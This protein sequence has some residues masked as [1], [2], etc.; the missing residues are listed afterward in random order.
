MA[1]TAEAPAGVVEVTTPDQEPEKQDN[2]LTPEQQAQRVQMLAEYNGLKSEIVDLRSE[3][4]FWEA[5]LE[6]PCM[7]EFLDGI[8]EQ[9]DIADLRWRKVDKKALP[10]LRDKANAQEWMRDELLTMRSKFDSELRSKIHQLADFR[11][12]RALFLSAEGYDLD[13]E[14]EEDGVVEEP[15]GETDADGQDDADEGVVSI[16]FEPAPD[17]GQRELLI[18][19]GY[20]I[21]FETGDGQVW[22]QPDDTAA[23]N[24]RSDEIKD[25]AQAENAVEVRFAK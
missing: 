16:T 20:T 18:A 17:K 7:I 4:A 5:T 19:L 11:E 2:E 23:D 1:I 3:A 12:N 21:S 25:L 9:L 22:E 10:E 13:A 24:R 15:D 6:D 14:A 8:Q